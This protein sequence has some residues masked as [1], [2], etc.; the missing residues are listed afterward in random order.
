[1]EMSQ[2]NPCTTII[3]WKKERKGRGGRRGEERRGEEGG[4]EKEG[5]KKEG[6]K[7][8]LAMMWGNGTLIHYWE[9]ELVQPL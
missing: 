6:R 8:I 9:C 1:M 4:G 2:Q 3:Y 5:G 7:E